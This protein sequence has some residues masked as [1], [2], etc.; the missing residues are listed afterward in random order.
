MRFPPT[1]IFTKAR[2]NLGSSVGVVQGRNRR[3]AEL[4]GWAW[5]GASRRVTN[6]RVAW[7]SRGINAPQKI[8]VERAWATSAPLASAVGEGGAQ[9]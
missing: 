3:P 8:E 2:Q 6:R 1:P 5:A 7:P 4:G 9:P